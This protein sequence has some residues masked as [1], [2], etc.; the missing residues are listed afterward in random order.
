MNKLLKAIYNDYVL[1]KKDK[2]HLNELIR[3]KVSKK[4]E[5]ELKKLK[6]KFK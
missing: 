1:N 2:N 4:Q 5:D 6:E 3:N